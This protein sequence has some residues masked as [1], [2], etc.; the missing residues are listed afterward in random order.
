MKRIYVNPLPV[1]LWHWFNALCFILLI[2]TGIQIRYIGQ[3]D[4]GLQFKTAV[5]L[6]NAAG[7]ALGGGF[8]FWLAF[9]LF[10]DKITVYQ[11][12]PTRFAFYQKAWDQVQYYSKG[13][14]F[15]DKNPHHVTPWRKFNPLQ[16]MTYQIVLMI[17]LPIQLATG[18]MLWKVKTFAV[19]IDLLGGVRV[20]DTIHVV[21]FV[22]FTA[23]ICMHAYMGSLGEKAS[24]HFKEMFT[25]YEELDDEAEGTAGASPKA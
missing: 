16:S 6:H 12:E 9:H 1:R 11:S 5:T 7:F 2:A 3:I 15:G 10:T 4:L 22:F 20:V 25:G 14:L 17:L 21:L 24:S 8:L 19:F 18:L 23:F 13:I